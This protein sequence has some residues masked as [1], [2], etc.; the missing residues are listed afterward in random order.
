MSLSGQL[1]DYLTTLPVPQGRRAG[2]AFEVL[3]WQRRFIRG[4]FAEGVQEA[5]LSVARG[6]GKSTLLAGVATASL[7]G[8]LAVQRGECLIV[9]SSFTQARVIFDHVC[10]ILRPER[11]R[12]RWKVWNT[13]QQAA[14]ECKVTGARVVCRASDPRRVHGLAPQLCL[15]DEPAQWPRS[16]GDSMLAALRT[17]LGKQE[18]A[19]LV[20]LGTRPASDSHF[21]QRMLDGGADYAQSHHAPEGAKH[22]TKGTWR[23]A[24][25]S[26]DHM[27]DLE[28]AIRGEA[29]KAK[30][31]AM[32]MPSF[33]A[34]RL[35]MGVSDIAENLLL[36]SGTWKG[37]EGEAPRAGACYW[38]ID[39]GTNAAQSAVTACWD[40]GRL[41][42][43]AAFPARPTLAER[44]RVDGVGDLY[45]HCSRRGELVQLGEHTTD[46]VGLLN[47]ALER[48]GRPAAISCDRWRLAELREALGKVGLAVP[49]IERGQGFKDGAEDVRSFR[50]AACDGRV[51]PIESLLLRAAIS[52][53]R[54]ISDPAGNEKLAKQSQGGRRYKAK[55]DAAAAAILAVSLCE[56]RRSRAVARRPRLY[57]M[58]GERVAVVG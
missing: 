20:A 21:F 26:L 55:D 4:A 46:L 16:T 50:R 5:A 35:N 24:N 43:L 57:T 30:R 10:T 17:S 6:N 45:V 22:W 52:E 29:D 47:L 53:A 13:S 2:E 38:G 9:A 51:T 58:D 12:R 42:A 36:E 18:T 8:P 33:E 39:L 28:R 11:D 14:I 27:P 25:P 23:K 3:A 32:L 54:T 15:L 56:A 1:I 44:G 40:S 48:Y 19:L 41:E 34:L 7:D 31:D 37:I 49:V